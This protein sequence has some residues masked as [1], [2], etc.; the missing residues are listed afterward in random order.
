MEASDRL[1]QAAHLRRARPIDHHDDWS[2]RSQAASPAPQEL[3]RA[4]TRHVSMKGRVARNLDREARAAA[5][6]RALCLGSKRDA[7]HAAEGIGLPMARPRSG[8][9]R[10]VL[11]ERAWHGTWG[12]QPLLPAV[13]CG[14]IFQ[15]VVSMSAPAFR[16]PVP[17]RALVLV[18][19]LSTLAVISSVVAWSGGD[20]SERTSALVAGT[21]A[22]LFLGGLVSLEVRTESLS[23]HPVLAEMADPCFGR[24]SAS[25]LRTTVVL[26][27]WCTTV[28]LRTSS[29]E[30]ARPADEP[31]EGRLARFV[32][33]GCATC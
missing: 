23:A 24:R 2:R 29:T 1:G 15:K 7:L 27:R 6:A 4:W 32:Y 13:L 14:G 12:L 10:R 9:A 3:S 17:V 25:V 19:I 20:V 33:R 21:A 16:R 31:Q 22:V 28:G 18:I 26:R 30:A 11:R 8:D 5:A